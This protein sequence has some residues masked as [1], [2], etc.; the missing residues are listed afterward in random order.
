MEVI[1]EECT[2]DL[3]GLQSKPRYTPFSQLKSSICKAVELPTTGASS[4]EAEDGAVQETATVDPYA[5]MYQQFC[6]GEDQVL[7][8]PEDQS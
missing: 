2:D 4:Q 7:D 5:M 8:I 1:L 6:F 3:E